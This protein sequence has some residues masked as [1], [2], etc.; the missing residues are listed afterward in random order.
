MSTYQPGIPTGTVNLDEDY[1]NIQGNFQQL[2]TTYGIDHIA[3]TDNSGTV[4]AGLNGA[5]K[6]LHMVPF[7]TTTSNPPN[8][9]PVVAPA[10][11]PGMGE[12]FTAKINDGASTDEALYYKSGD[13]G[14]LTQ[15][16][17]NFQPTPSTNGY[18]FLPGGL[19]LQWGMKVSTG[20][21]QSVTLPRSFPA[22]FYNAQAT[23]IR[24]SSNIDAIY[25]ITT[26]TAGVITSLQ[27]RDTSSGNNFFWWAIGN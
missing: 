20:G 19:I 24:N 2:Q 15:L 9:Q 11:V 26:P 22:N 7:S 5:H 25:C 13:N 21:V 6:T 10:A 4:P 16:T 17:R 18:T 3:L 12:L 8:N 23:M 27:F 14:Y 1:L